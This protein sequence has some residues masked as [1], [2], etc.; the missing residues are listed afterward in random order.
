LLQ[1]M[2]LVMALKSRADCIA[3]GQLT[4]VLRM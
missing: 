3:V 2:S 4:E 1:C